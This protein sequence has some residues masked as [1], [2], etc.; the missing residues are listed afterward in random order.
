MGKSAATVNRGPPVHSSGRK[1]AVAAPASSAKRGRKTAVKA[2]EEDSETEAEEPAAKTSSR[3]PPLPHAPSGGRGKSTKRES[4]CIAEADEGP[5][6]S[7][8][9]IIE[10]FN[11]HDDYAAPVETAEIRSPPAKRASGPSRARAHAHAPTLDLAARPA[12]AKASAKKAPTPT[13]VVSALEPAAGGLP[14]SRMRTASALKKQALDIAPVA[15]GIAV[16]SDARASVRKQSASREAHVDELEV[17]APVSSPLNT[18]HDSAEV[19]APV[20]SP[21]NTTHDSN[22]DDDHAVADWSDDKAIPVA[23]L[24]TDKFAP[25]ASSTSLS[26]RRTTSATTVTEPTTGAVSTL[27]SAQLRAS[28]MELSTMQ[29]PDKNG[30]AQQA[31]LHDQESGASAKPKAKSGHESLQMESF[32]Q[33]F[34]LTQGTSNAN[35]SEVDGGSIASEEEAAKKTTKP[36]AKMSKAAASSNKRKRLEDVDEELELEGDADEDQDVGS[37]D[38]SGSSREDD[39]FLST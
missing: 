18:T 14:P 37:S 20:S 34:N 29:N 31:A 3:K 4:M 13:T 6:E 22:M 10:D 12:M 23:S 21:L 30:V 24:G 9:D 5:Y 36:T 11:S 26:W 8:Q 27:I 7:L 1:P 16:P 2:V 35:A 25:G 19:G 38:Q 32:T 33:N 28:R 15:A 39:A 17:G